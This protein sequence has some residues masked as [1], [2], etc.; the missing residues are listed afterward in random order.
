MSDVKR[1]A[2]SA[3]L[4]SGEINMFVS[5]KKSEV[6][7]ETVWV[8]GLKSDMFSHTYPGEHCNPPPIAVSLPHMGRCS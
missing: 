7:S 8:E 3:A 5:K 2:L 4:S 1:I 6:K